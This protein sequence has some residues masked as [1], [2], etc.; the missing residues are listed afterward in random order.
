MLYVVAA[1]VTTSD[2]EK[3]KERVQ[4]DRT[5]VTTHLYPLLFYP[6]F[7]RFCACLLAVHH[8]SSFVPNPPVSIF[9]DRG[10]IERRRAARRDLRNRLFL[11]HRSYIRFTAS[12]PQSL[13]YSSTF[14]LP[15]STGGSN[16][17]FGQTVPDHQGREVLHYRWRRIRYAT[18]RNSTFLHAPHF[19]YEFKLIISGGD[20]HNVKGGHW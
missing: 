8:P 5:R 16:N 6:R 14:P 13:S 18:F 9:V 4:E 17:G 3:K 1:V 2:Q 15:P 19:M 12:R 20:Y 11:L 10:S 7:S